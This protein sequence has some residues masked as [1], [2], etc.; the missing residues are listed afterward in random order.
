MDIKIAYSPCPNDTYIFDAMVNNKIDHSFHC[1]VHLE[2]IKTLNTWAQE[3]KF[4]VIKLSFHAFAYLTD[5]YQ[6]LP[7]GS[8]LG[9][10]VGPL[11]VSDQIKTIEELENLTV[12]IP[13]E[14]TTAN[15]LLDY[16]LGLKSINKKVLV[17]NEIEDGIKNGIIDAGVIIHENRFTYESKGLKKIM[18]LGTN[19]ENKTKLPIPLGGI[20]IKR[21]LAA[22]IKREFAKTLQS[23]IAFAF[24]H[25]IDVMSY[26]KNHAQTMNID[27]MNKH[28]ELY[29]NQFTKDITLK[30]K[31]AIDF[32]LN[33][34]V[35]IGKI[36]TYNK[37]YMLKFDSF[38]Y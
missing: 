18:D 24:D 38:Q 10:G 5:A 27:V 3:K 35:E 17:F 30:G 29:V 14:F 31:R 15:F 28:I 11:L 34:F 23:S 21:S 2:D 12:G 7:I 9:E 19:W 26:V 33:L 36:E 16:A 22:D 8:A 25:P 32:L 4:D 13:G 1:D 6:L 37:S 20:A